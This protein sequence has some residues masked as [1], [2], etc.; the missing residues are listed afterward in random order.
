MTSLKIRVDMNLDN[1][2]VVLPCHSLE[3]L[4]LDRSSV[5]AEQILSAWSALYHP[6]LI[7]RFRGPPGWRGAINAPSPPDGHLVAVPPCCEDDL[8]ADWLSTADGADAVVIRECEHRDEILAKAL[9][10]LDDPA[11]DG[12]S[13]DLVNDFLALGY[14]HLLVELLTRQLRYMS[15]LDEVAFESSTL[16]A[17]EKWAE[18]DSDAAREHLTSAFDLLTEAREYFYPVETHLLDFTLVVPTTIGPALDDALARKAPTNLVLSGAT[19]EAIAEQAPDTM[20]E[21]RKALEAGELSVVG[22]EYEERELPLLGPET[23]LAQFRRGRETYQRLLGQ[24]PKIYFRRRFGLS[25]VLPQILA[26][27]GFSGACH[28]TLDD[29]RFPTGNQS[30]IKWEGIS[31]ASIDSLVRLPCDA[32]RA[33]TFLAL[34]ERLGNAMDLD[35]AA[36]ALFAHWPGKHSVWY[37]DLIRACSYSPVLGRFFSIEEYFKDTKYVGQAT[38][39]PSDGYRSPFLRQAVNRGDKKPLSQWQDAAREEIGDQVNRSLRTMAAMIGGKPQENVDELQAIREGLA[40]GSQQTGPGCLVVNPLPFDRKVPVDISGWEQLP[41]VGNSII[42]A[43]EQ[44]ERKTAIVNVPGMGFAWIDPHM[45]PPEEP[46]EPK[47][48]RRWLGAKKEPETPPMAEE[49]LLRNDFFE[50][51][52]DPATGA[53]R[54]IHDYRTRDNRLAM[55]LAYRLAPQRSASSPDDEEI[56]SVMAADEVAV[57]ESG[58]LFGEMAIR[59]RLLTRDGECLA[60][61]EQVLRARRGN[62]VLEIDLSL[63]PERLPSGDPWSNYYAARFAWSDATTD[64]FTGL[65]TATLATESPQLEAPYFID[66]RCEKLNT[67]ILT[68]GLPY[69]RRFGLRKMD[70]LLIVSGETQRNFRLGIGIDVAHP[71]A[72]TSEFL[73]P[74]SVLT[75]VGAAPETRS[76]WLFHINAKNV[77]TTSWE[78]IYDGQKLRGV[79]ARLAETENRGGEF[80][81]RCF[82][83]VAKARKLDLLGEKIEELPVDGD[84]V[85]VPAKGHEWT[86]IEIDFK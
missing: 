71:Y 21:I 40:P 79:R 4:S 52:V 59:G 69:H 83:Q 60:R 55:Q 14:C 70:T 30:R 33:G 86:Q 2:T 32:G 81:V 66:L 20:T 31:N 15:N 45:P 75:D 29:G 23:T 37:D 35:H 80:A 46:P 9:E 67:T 65:G 36:T 47:M 6:A 34:A 54:S 18:G 82:C 16:S 85:T 72:A 84:R 61:Y 64:F 43:A 39:Y 73:A 53:V 28:F 1:L 3:D 42:A 74:E 77:V 38:R 63:D 41:P 8:P 10:A 26:K 25:S 76:G 58:P 62:R 22:G 44:S 5:E 56:Y 13:S 68:G 19:L 57:R 24:A 50:V 7:L 48:R 27:S 11:P 17:A 51:K 78:P 49:N 12:S